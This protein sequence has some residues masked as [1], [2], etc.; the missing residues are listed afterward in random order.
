M[1]IPVTLP[2]ITVIQIGEGRETL[3][4]FNI[5]NNGNHSCNLIAL[6][7]TM[8]VPSTGARGDTSDRTI[9]MDGRLQFSQ[10]H[11][12]R[13]RKYHLFTMAN[14]E[15]AQRLL[16]MLAAHNMEIILRLGTPTL[17]AAGTNN[18][19]RHNNIFGSQEITGYFLKCNTDPGKQPPTTDHMP[20]LLAVDLT[21][22]YT[23]KHPKPNYRTTDWPAFQEAMQAALRG[24]LAP[25]EI[26]TVREFDSTFE[27]LMCV[28]NK[29]IKKHVPTTKALPHS[30]R[31]WKKELPKPGQ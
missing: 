14:L 25:K 13:R 21:P 31:L 17:K 11:V 5:Y 28:M 24:L 7:C 18:H 8:C 27:R 4:I 19:T 1:Q 15:A 30:K 26:R 9:W 10:H 29:I 16:E 22:M 3:R 12:G 23:T 6:D 20:I 2:N